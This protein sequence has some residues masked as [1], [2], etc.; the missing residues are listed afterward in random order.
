MSA[1]PLLLCVLVLLWWTLNGLVWTGQVVT[2]GEA[3]G[4]P[5]ALE[6]A[7][8]MQLASAWLWA[9]LTLALFWCVRRW[10]VE[11]GRVLRA[12]A[13][14]GLAVAAVIVL[15]ALAVRL[16]NDAVGWYPAL[17][18]FPDVLAAS[19][20]NN[21]LMGWLI[22][23]VAHAWVYAGRA[24]R[25]EREAI[26]LGARLTEARLQ[27]LSAQ[28]NPHFLFNALNS[29][30][31]TVHRDPE[32]ADRMLVDLGAMLRHSLD[33]SRRQLVALREEL[34]AL[35]HYIGIERARLGERLQV[36]WTIDS[37][38]LDAGVPPLLLQ[39]LVENAIRHAVAARGDAGAICVRAARAGGRLVLE[40]LDDGAHAPAP[41]GTGVGLSNTRA[42]LQCLYGDDHQ[43]VIAPRR[44]GGTRV[45]LSVPCRTV[46]AAA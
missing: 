4:Q 40:V 1:R 7:L 10:P 41:R 9:P 30:A 13:A 28:L 2:M 34:A 15:R 23:G 22:V 46:G 17:P 11:P 32:A 45:W 42:R 29:I 16:L 35:D 25:R 37:D 36:Q 33:T 20:L 27:A 24:R 43:L 19:V 14:H 31:E 44:G 12:L 39:P 6:R 3:T 38:L 5:V 8:R 18:P 21:L 26:E